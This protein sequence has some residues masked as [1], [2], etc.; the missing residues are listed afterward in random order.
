MAIVPDLSGIPLMA[1]GV[2]GR[3]VDRKLSDANR[4]ISG[5]PLGTTTPQYTGERILDS[6]GYQLWAATDLTTTGW[7]PITMVT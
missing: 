5:S 7:H 6:V 2:A 1:N 3:N 4:V